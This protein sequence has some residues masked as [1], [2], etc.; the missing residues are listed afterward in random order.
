LRK[1]LAILTLV[2]NCLCLQAQ[3]YIRGEVK[4]EK[5]AILQNAVIKPNNSSLSFQSGRYGDFGISWSKKVDT[6]SV[7]LQGYE[8]VKA[9]MNGD[10]FNSI[11]LKM[12][13]GAKNFN[14]KSLSSLTKNLLKDQGFQ[15]S[16]FGE[17]YSRI[18]END[19][20]YS[21]N[22]PNTGFALNIDKASYSNI[23]RFLTQKMQV[24]H[25]AVRIEEMINYFQLGNQL[26]PKDNSTFAIKSTMSNCPW[27]NSN[28]LLFLNINARKINLDKVPPS[29]LVFLLDISGSMDMPNR[30]PLIKSAF[31]MLVNNLRKIDTV[32]IVYYGGGV[33]I[34]LHATSGN[35]KD[36]INR[37]IEQLEPSGSTPG[38]GGIQTAYRL[39][40]QHF[41]KGGNNRVILATDGDFNIGQTTDKELEEIITKQAE[42]GVQL[43]CLGVGMG[44]YK[45]SKL[46]VLAKKGNGNFAYLDTEKEAEKVMVTEFTQTLYSVAN[47]VFVNMEF[48]PNLVSNY[49]LIGFDN[50]SDALSDSTSSLDGGEVGSGHSIV[51]IFEIEPTK[52]NALLINNSARSTEPIANMKLQYKLPNTTN[53]LSIS[54]ACS[55]NFTNFDMIDPNLRLATSIA[56]FGDLL[57]EGKN[58]KFRWE[59]VLQMAQS[60]IQKNDVLHLELINLIQNAS[61]IYGITKKTKKQKKEA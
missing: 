5:N 57:R 38:A 47:D 28:Q 45:D 27:N 50:K 16:L 51:A 33:G 53:S 36:S 44:N 13:T 35:E 10:K 48:N 4:D 24:P 31:K 59:D 2:F 17:T 37:V 54:H 6:F 29:N 9:V 11:V 23:R 25:D 19:F 14:K 49:R 18:I 1:T 12:K 20:V 26:T 41:I 61:R 30:M 46:E 60:N 3:F 40:K 55:F 21:N 42:T 22:F 56:M 15:Q 58:A 32:S 34:A 39:A 7:S 52:K 8:T 43:T